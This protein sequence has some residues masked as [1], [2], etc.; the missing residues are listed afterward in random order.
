MA[1]ETDDDLA[2][3]LR[4]C[5][6]ILLWVLGFSLFVNVLMLVP[7]LYMLQV[8]D[9]VLATG[10]R[11][12]LILLTLVALFLLAVMGLLD[13]VRGRL[14]VRAGNYLDTCLGP[15]L[16]HAVFA[17]RVAGKGGSVQPLDDLRTLRQFVS[18][19]G[20]FAFFDAP[21]VP[22]YLALLFLF[23]PWLGAFASL[24]GLI[25]I[26]LTLANEKA[27]R[28]LMGEAGE[29]Y[30]EARGQVSDSLNGA[31]VVRS[32]GMLPALRQRWL[33]GHRIGL[34]M[35]S[36]ASDRASGLTQSARTLRLASQSLI[37]GL[38]ALLV[39]E[40]SITPGVM[41]AAS[42]I[43]ARALAPIDSM[44]GGWR[45]FVSARDAYRRLA[46]LLREV[47]AERQRL[48]L[49]APQGA[50]AVESVTLRPPG[51]ERAVLDGITF[52]VAP[53]EH[54]GIIGPSAAGKSSLARLLIGAQLPER[55]TI[56]LD[57]ASLEHWDRALLGPFLGYLPQEIELFDGTVSDNIAR[58]GELC[59][60]RVV[61]AAR[62]AGVHD[63]IL[64]LPDGYETR[65]GR[66]GTMLS[67][68]QR[69]RVALARALY[70][71]PVLVVL[72]EPNA[73][74]D[75]AGERALSAALDKLKQAGVSVIV[76][77]HRRSVLASVDTLLLLD[78]GRL[79]L[80][81][82]RDDVLSRLDADT[83]RRNA[84]AA[85]GGQ[86]PEPRRAAREART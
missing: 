85:F 22:L 7:A 31:E 47:P 5:R 80:R 62:K 42:I 39:L 37:L 66:S 45:S 65:L 86:A 3:A 64:R 79:R 82:A 8:Y 12:T 60:H 54:V 17:Q 40:G 9:R 23:H 36:R 77:T 1:S 41:I 56:R 68:G 58:F 27:T 34:A 43:L 67:R 30:R 57:G 52:R 72:D 51:S 35:Q 19:N 10:S 26:G 28:G 44:I 16:Y 49:P 11:E 4:K 46:K 76:I 63:M 6:P 25:L 33:A 32:L 69:Q 83:S 71:D 74:L 53:G 48:A 13:L 70:G 50:V 84:T 2:G 29:R 18:G 81:G 55:G 21:W 59:A 38:G 78:E 14:L 61:E 15:R 24:A 20:L 73:N 75:D